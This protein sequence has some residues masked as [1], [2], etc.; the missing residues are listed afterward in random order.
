MLIAVN[1]KNTTT[2]LIDKGAHISVIDQRT[3]E[4]KA[5][6]KKEAVSVVEFNSTNNTYSDV[7]TKYCLMDVPYDPC[8]CAK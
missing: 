1:D 5:P 6:L 4:G 3:Y 8:Y 7:W 2:F